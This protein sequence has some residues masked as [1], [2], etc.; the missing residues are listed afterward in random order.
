MTG[1]HSPSNIIGVDDQDFL[2]LLHRRFDYDPDEGVFIRR[3]GRGGPAGQ[4]AGSLNSGGYRQ[5]H[6]G[7]HP[8]RNVLAHR[9][10]WLFCHGSWPEGLLDH[11]NGDKDDNRIANLRETTIARNLQNRHR[12]NPDNLSGLLGVAK[13]GG[14]W[15]ASICVDGR[16]YHL[17]M[18]GT[19]EEAHEAYLS[20][21]RE[22]HPFW[23]AS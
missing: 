6:V 16:Q 19:P 20:A 11:R 18:F 14:R 8:P 5:I 7:G 23:E 21:K 9:M 1:G 2:E 4:I 3:K 17:G 15:R 12:P 22:L 13:S 10:A